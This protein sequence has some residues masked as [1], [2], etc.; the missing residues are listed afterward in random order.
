MMAGNH[1]HSPN[2]HLVRV[3]QSCALTRRDRA[4]REWEHLPEAEGEAR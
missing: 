2:Y 1:H 4:W 3:N